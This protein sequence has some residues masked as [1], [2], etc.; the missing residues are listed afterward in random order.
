MEQVSALPDQAYTLGAKYDLGM[1]KAVQK[2][3]VFDAPHRKWEG[4]LKAR[5]TILSYEARIG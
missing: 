1:P 5:F 3:T 2:E 4:F